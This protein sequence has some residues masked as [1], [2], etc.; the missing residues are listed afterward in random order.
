MKNWRNL[1]HVVLVCALLASVASSVPKVIGS[2]ANNQQLTK[3]TNQKYGCSVL[4]PL[5]VFPNP[6]QQSDDEHAK[7]LSTD[8]RTMLELI[9]DQNPRKRA[10]A[11]VYRDWIAECK[12]KGAIGYKTL[13]GNWFVVSGDANGRGYYTKCVDRDNKLFIMN[14]EYDEDADAI[15]ESTMTTMSRRFTGQQERKEEEQRQSSQAVYAKQQSNAATTATVASAAEVNQP[16]AT[17]EQTAT[18]RPTAAPQQEVISW[19]EVDAIYNLKSKKTNLQKD[20]LWSRFKGKRVTWTGKVSSMSEG[21][22][23]GLS[24]QVKMNRE[25]FT[26]DLIIDLK[27]SQKDRAMQFEEGDTVRFTGI[28]REWGTLMPITIEDGEILN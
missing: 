28:L 26:S 6:P 2:D 1:A 21:W 13:K 10:L 17:V 11:E 3:F 27:P 8:G 16:Q 12:K 14:I 18:P 25:T 7:F 24:M 22:L 19:R 5:D 15:L 23:G 9:V 20:A 4:L